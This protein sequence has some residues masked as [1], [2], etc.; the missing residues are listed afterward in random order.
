M[1]NYIININLFQFLGHEI[2]GRTLIPPPPLALVKPGGPMNPKRLHVMGSLGCVLV[3]QALDRFRSTRDSLNLLQDQQR[4][5]FLRAG[6][7]FR[8]A[9]IPLLAR[10]RH[11]L[12][13]LVHPHKIFLH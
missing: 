7:H 5:F 11:D 13:V 1:V 12:S 3:P 10:S 9:Y 2:I 6:S 4:P 8:A